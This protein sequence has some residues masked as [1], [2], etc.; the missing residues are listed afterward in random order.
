MANAYAR[1]GTHAGQDVILDLSQMISCWEGKNP[2]C[3]IFHM[4]GIEEPIEVMVDFNDFVADFVSYHDYR[5]PK[6]KPGSNPPP[7]SVPKLVV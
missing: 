5:V 3:T 6:E 1:F 4:F 2:G 7:G